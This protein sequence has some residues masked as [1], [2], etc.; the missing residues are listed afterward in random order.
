MHRAFVVV[1]V[2][3]S[4]AFGQQTV[5]ERTNYRSTSRHADV[6]AFCNELAK[7]SPVVVR[8]DIGKSRE[9]RVLP[10]LVLADPPAAS[11]AEAHKNGKMVVLV[12]ANIHA[13]EVNGKEAVLMLARDIATGADKAL[14]KDLVILII[15][16]LNADGNER[17]DKAH[18]TE[19]NGPAG[20]VGIRANADGYDLNRDFIKLET[21]EVRSLARV[22]NR[23]DPA[24]I[25]NMHTTDGS[26]H[27][28]TLTYDGPRNPAA[29]PD[30][31]ATVRDQWLPEIGRAIERDA[32]YKSFFYGNFAANHTAWESYPPTPRYGIQWIAMRNRVALLS[33]SYTYAPFKDRVL[34]GRAYVRAIFQYVAAHKD[35]VRKM[36]AKADKPRDRIALRTKTTSLGERT[37]LGYVEEMKDG[38]RAPTKTTKDYKLQ[39]MIGMEATV[40]VQRPWAYLVPA[41]YRSAIETLQRHGIVVESLSQDAQLD[42]QV[43]KVVRVTKASRVFQKHALMTLDVA[44]RDEKRKISAGTCVVRTDQR[45]GTLA[46]YLLEP[47]SEDGLTTWNFLDAGLMKDKDFPVLRVPK[48]AKV[49]TAPLRS[50][51]D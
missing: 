16:I 44:R 41:S 21:P 35:A 30:M 46:G 24:V 39:L 20:G 32:G 11:A 49:R 37:V 28:Y 40:L 6:L 1:I 48:Q 13:G 29:D 5:A 14:L 17:I 34:A 38:K 33:E 19:Q 4:A 10:M 2:A 3:V 15:P 25:V 23:W 8:Q 12:F 27:R 36:L 22:I 9:G 45:L 47:Q 42:V 18:R 43:Y 51:N 31:I 7:R 50:I 26:F